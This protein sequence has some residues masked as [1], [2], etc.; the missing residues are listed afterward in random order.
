[1]H[2]VFLGIGSNI[3]PEE[4]IRRAAAEIASECR[5][6]AFSSHI[7][8]PPLDNRQ[9]ADYINAVWKIETELPETALKEHLLRIEYLLGRRRSDDRYAPREIDLD[10]LVF[11]GKIVDDAVSSRDFV[12]GPL[13]EIEPGIKISG[14]ENNL[15][16]LPEFK[17]KYRLSGLKTVLEKE[18]LNGP[19]KS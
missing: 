17:G 9:E 4:N 13:L 6:L 15:K 11:D 10:I 14:P 7:I 16:K 8:T 1:M 12:Y 18:Y 2:T 19:E 5:I 3:R